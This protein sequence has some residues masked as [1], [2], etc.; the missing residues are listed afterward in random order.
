M[1]VECSLLQFASAKC[2]SMS[3]LQAA[4]DFLLALGTFK[5]SRQVHCEG[6]RCKVKRQKVGE[7]GAE[8]GPQ[9]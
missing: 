8:E 4:D 9:S 6:E 3:V 5:G 7:K 1:E 2:M